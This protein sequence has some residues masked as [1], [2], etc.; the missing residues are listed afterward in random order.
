MQKFFQVDA[1][2]ADESFSLSYERPMIL[3][4]R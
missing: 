3:H 4:F 2:P 1:D